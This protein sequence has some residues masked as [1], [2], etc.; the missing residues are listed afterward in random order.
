MDTA[1]TSL[2]LLVT[3]M[4]PGGVQAQPPADELRRA[5]DELA[6][7]LTTKQRDVLD[8][9]LAPDFVLRGQPDV[10]REAWL[11]NALSLCWGDRFELTDFALRS[12][13]GD[14]AV[15]TLVLTTHRD[16]KTCEPAV[17]TSVITDFW[18]RRAGEPGWRLAMRHSGPAGTDVAQQSAKTAPPPP[19][20]ER[21][22]ELSLVA[23]GGN[24]DTQTLGAGGSM[25]WRPSA[26][27]TR[28]TA[29][30]VRSEADDIDTAESLAAEL[31]VSRALSRRLEA[32]GRTSYLANRF[33]GIDYRTT[34]DA[35]LAWLLLEDARHSLKVD[36]AVGITH[37]SRLDAVDLTFAAG[38][39]GALY[40]WK[41][42]TST[43]LTEQALL[44]TDLGEPGNWRLQNGL[45]LTTSMTRVFSLKLSH[46]LQRINRPVPGFR[47][48][49][50]VL[51]AA[52]VAKF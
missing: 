42:S 51:A 36:A 40:K 47:R 30:Y 28:A 9:L 3:L 50:T 44:T 43:E 21:T 15:T 4:L 1:F 8:R 46:Q 22:A 27:V 38:S 12:T 31:R 37:E 26:W 49:D 52:L 32:F 20:W 33:A 19:R 35:G 24:T 11:T 45:A 29:A 14:T 23:T 7:A 16:P 10:T 39:G 18:V 6:T 2:A 48:T 25:I 5:E 13:S 41:V 17:I 34:T